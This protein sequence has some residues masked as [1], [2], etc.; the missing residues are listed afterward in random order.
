MVMDPELYIFT[1]KLDKFVEDLA[2]G[3]YY[4]SFDDYLLNWSDLN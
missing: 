2:I 3:I 1:G 4:R